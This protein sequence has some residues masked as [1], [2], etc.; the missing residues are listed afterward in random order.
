LQCT[1]SRWRSCMSPLLRSCHLR[2]QCAPAVS[3]SS[4]GDLLSTLLH[5]VP[6]SYNCILDPATAAQA[7]V[8]QAAVAAKRSTAQVEPSDHQE[9]WLRCS[10][11]R[12]RHCCR[13]G[14]TEEHGLHPLPHLCIRALQGLPCDNGEP[15]A[16][17]EVTG[18]R[19]KRKT[20]MC[21]PMTAVG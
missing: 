11:C 9:C 7:I 2:V 18:I 20:R 4:D 14:W 19:A 10:R 5:H 13:G 12:I 16:K 21:I 1:N 6:L 3:A 17:T 8:C 15:G